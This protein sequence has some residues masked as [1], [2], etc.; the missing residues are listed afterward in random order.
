MG[1]LDPEDVV[2]K[3]IVVV[4]WREA[5]EAELGAVDHDLAKPSNLRV[6][7]ELAQRGPPFSLLE[8]RRRGYDDVRLRAVLGENFMRLFRRA[9]PAD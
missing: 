1:A 4:R 3:Q 5:S 7:A 6:D 8:L 9:L 2:E